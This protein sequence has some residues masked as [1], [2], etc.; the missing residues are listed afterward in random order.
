MKLE[1]DPIT[2]DEWLL[3]RI[4]A[5]RVRLNKTPIISPNAFEPLM[6]GPKVR[7]PDIDGINLYR[8]ACLSDPNEVLATVDP[9]RHSEFAIA[10][11]PI[12]LIKMLQLTVVPIFDS[13]VP[14]HVVI[15]E[16]STNFYN[17]NEPR[18]KIILAHLAAVASEPA[19]LL[20]RPLPRT[21]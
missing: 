2:D 16:L 12:S 8:M 1:S 7:H 18:F 3:R 21:S 5:V 13:R 4:P 19:N 17:S 15:P 6:P 20:L 14:G 10:R 11:I 9:S